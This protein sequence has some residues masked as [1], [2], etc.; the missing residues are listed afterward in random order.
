M[1][2]VSKED[3]K[4]LAKLKADLEKRSLGETVEIILDSWE[5]CQK[6]KEKVADLETENTELKKKLLE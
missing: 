1:I 3:H 5:E 6:L 4:R 2:T